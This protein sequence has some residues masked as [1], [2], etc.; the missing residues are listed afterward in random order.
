ME[1]EHPRKCLKCGHEH[2]VKAGKER[3]GKQRWR[4]CDCQR[5]FVVA[6][7]SYDEAFREQVLHAVREG[8]SQ[9]GACRVFG[10]ARMSVAT[11]LKKSCELACT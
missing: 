8:M 4:C 7:Q 1:K 10:I 9:R 5:V 11:W 3:N 2:V 6:D